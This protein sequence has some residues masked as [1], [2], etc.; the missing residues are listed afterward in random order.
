METR[1]KHKQTREQ[2]ETMV[3]KAFPG[4]GG[5]DILE[6]TEGAFN[7]AYCITLKD[8]QEVVLKVA[9]QPEALIMS[10]EKNIMYSEVLGMRLVQELTDVPVPEVLYYDS[11]RTNCASDY[12][13]MTKLPGQS[14]SSLKEAGAELDVDALK[15]TVGCL[16]QKL[17]TIQG[18]LFGYCGQP[19]QQ[20]GDWH[21]VFRSMMQTAIA[22]AQALHIDM[23][24]DPEEILRLLDQDRALFQEI[25]Q[26]LFVHWDLWDGNVFVDDGKVVGLIDLERCLWGDPLLEVGFRTHEY[27]ENFLRGYGKT[28][29]TPS[30][31]RRILWYDLY[32][33]ALVCLEHDYR[34]YETWDFYEWSTD[35][36]QHTLPRLRDK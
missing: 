11:S 2:L 1:A 35:G 23:T 31:Q 5:G 24:V 17:N 21:A 26:P 8:G 29:F 28:A 16:N 22:D 10:Y 14:L 6:L 4:M 27:D 32:F 36:L 3:E 25:T 13:F 34:Q 18:P 30:E 19:D 20:G 12:F 7:E 9:P 33:F 15:H